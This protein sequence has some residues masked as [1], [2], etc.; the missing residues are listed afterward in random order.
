MKYV[1]SGMPIGAM[2]IALNHFELRVHGNTKWSP[3]CHEASAEGLCHGRPNHQT[4]EISLFTAPRRSKEFSDKTL[5]Y[6]S[7]G[8][9][10]CKFAFRSYLVHCAD[11]EMIIHVSTDESRDVGLC[12][13]VISS[14]F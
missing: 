13:Y 7:K 10:I 8:Q 12:R 3:T 9:G 11:K 5:R 14:I 1:S 2:M 6:L 4:Y